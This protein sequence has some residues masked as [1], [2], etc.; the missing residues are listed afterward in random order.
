MHDVLLEQ[1]VCTSASSSIAKC[2][3]AFWFSVVAIDPLVAV[4]WAPWCSAGSRR[5]KLSVA[6]KMYA[7]DI[8]PAEIAQFLGRDKSTLTRRLCKCTPLKQQG[9]KVKVTAA[10][11]D[12]IE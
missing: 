12:K 4:T 5:R 9:R 10:M 2:I 3:C 11:V 7:Q 1:N 6:K 8:A